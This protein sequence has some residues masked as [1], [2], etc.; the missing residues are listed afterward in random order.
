MGAADGCGAPAFPTNQARRPYAGASAQG[1]SLMPSDHDTDATIHSARDANIDH[2]AATLHRAM[3]GAG[4]VAQLSARGPV[5]VDLAYAIQARGLALR[6]ADGERSVGIKMGFTSRAKMVQMGVSETIFGRL[7]DAMQVAP[8]GSVAHA[9]FIH[10]RAE[11]ELAFVLRRPVRGAI[12][13]DEARAAVAAVCPAIELI[14]SRYENFEFSLADVVAD[15]SSSAAFVLGAPA[16]ADLAIE[17]LAVNFLIDGTPRQTGSTAA[18]LG[19]PW[20]S[21]VEAA[22]FAERYDLALEPGDVILAGAATEAVAVAPGSHVRVDIEGMAPLGFS[23][24]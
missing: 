24:A 17:D 10:P 13:I 16:P 22:R 14:D 15:N 3:R 21:L 19:N 4:A 1:P 23:L 18:I 20:L 7:T 6:Q 11:P 8:S 12:T 2:H 5:P 9:R